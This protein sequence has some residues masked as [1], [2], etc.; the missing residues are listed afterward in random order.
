M[1]SDLEQSYDE[2]DQVILDQDKRSINQ[3][4]KVD[5]ERE[6]LLDKPLNENF[7]AMPVVT[8]EITEDRLTYAYKSV[9]FHSY[10]DDDA[11]VFKEI[12]DGFQTFLQTSPTFQKI[13]IVATKD[14][15][16]PVEIIID[17]EHSLS[18]FANNLEEKSVITINPIKLK[19]QDNHMEGSALDAALF[20]MINVARFPALNHIDD[21]AKDGYYKI[22]SEG[23]SDID[24]PK[25]AGS[26]YAEDWESVEL[27]N[28]VPHHKIFQE[29]RD[30]GMKIRDIDDYYADYFDENGKLPPFTT[31]LQETHSLG[32]TELY[33]NFYDETIAPTLVTNDDF[34]V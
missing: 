8:G 30:G 13:L 2:S 11:L 17:W 31:L 15:S 27:P 3:W 18:A 34:E 28:L 14:G 9:I 25:S 20:E 23:R 16:A 1:A 29:A 7:G 26:L 32:H 12:D 10:L 21:L 22:L 33:K 6:I 4:L 19:K 24:K 5:S